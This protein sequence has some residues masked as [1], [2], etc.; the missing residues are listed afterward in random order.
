MDI[1]PPLPPFLHSSS[2]LDVRTGKYTYSSCRD[3]QYFYTTC[4]KSKGQFYFPSRDN[5]QM[6]K[7]SSQFLMRSQGSH[8]CLKSER[9]EQQNLN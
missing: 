3:R 9:V 1:F 7:Q 8:D 6:T 2:A 4:S 5:I